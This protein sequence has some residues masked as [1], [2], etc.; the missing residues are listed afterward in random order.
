MSCLPL[1][2]LSK[3]QRS[4]VELQ[5]EPNAKIVQSHFRGQTSLKA[6]QIMRTF[7][8]QAE[9]VQHLIVDGL[10]NLP[11]TGQPATQGFG[12]ALPFAA[13]MWRSDQ[14]DLILLM[15]A[16]SRSLTSKAFVS[17]IRSLSGQAAA[18]QLG[19]R[20]LASGKQGRSQVLVVGTRAPKAE[21]RNHPL[22]GDAQQ[23]VEAFVPPDAI[24]P[25][26][27]CLTRQPAQAAPLRITG[28]HSHAVQDFIGRL[29]PVQKLHQEQRKGGDR[30]SIGSLQSIELAPMG[31]LRERFSQM[32][33]RIA[34]KR[35]FAGKLHPLPKQGQRDHL[36]SAQRCL[37]TWFGSL[38]L[39]FRLAKIV[40]HDVQCCYEGIQIDHQR[41]PFLTN[42]FSKLTVR[43]GSLLFNPFLIHTKR[44]RR[45]N[46][47]QDST[48]QTELQPFHSGED[49]PPITREPTG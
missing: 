21:T 19:R 16:P 26:D 42:W 25:A 6:C 44:L 32:M 35:S 8:S 33:L 30:I 2:Q 38:W 22:C 39:V 24:T 37:R 34:I 10:N 28:H 49:I 36:T 23:K 20:R 17:H 4:A 15:P 43:P 5:I 13:L 29:L 47:M 3:S 40:Y 1:E 12:P 14:I 46:K 7:A 31:Q 41:A 45:R 48:V 9:R 18:S 27:I 11:Q